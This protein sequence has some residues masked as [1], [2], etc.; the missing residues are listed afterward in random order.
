VLVENS[1]SSTSSV[2]VEKVDLTNKAKRFFSWVK[3]FFGR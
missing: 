3:K 1:E 2:L